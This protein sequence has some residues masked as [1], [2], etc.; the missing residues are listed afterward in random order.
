[1]ARPVRAAR[2]EDVG[3]ANQVRLNVGVRVLERVAHPGLRREVQHRVRFGARKD[4]LQRGAIRDVLVMEAEARMLQALQARLLQ[5]HRVV[6]GQAVDAGHFVAARQQ[7]L[8]AVHADEPG[9]ARDQD[10]QRVSPLRSSMSLA[11]FM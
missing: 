11:Y 4:A 5:L 7:A 6:V 9:D 2:F 3:E 1:M 8:R 10:P